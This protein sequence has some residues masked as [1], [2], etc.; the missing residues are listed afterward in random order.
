MTGRARKATASS[1]SGCKRAIFS[2]PQLEKPPNLSRWLFADDARAVM[3]DV[4]TFWEQQETEPDAELR[5][6][7]DGAM[8]TLSIPS[9][10][11]CDADL[12]MIK[13]AHVLGVY[14]I[15]EL[16]SLNG[17]QNLEAMSVALEPAPFTFVVALRTAAFGSS[18][19]PSPMATPSSAAPGTHGTPPSADL[20]LVDIVVT[21]KVGAK[22]V[23]L[24]RPMRVSAATTFAQLRGKVLDGMAADQAA[25]VRSLPAVATAFRSGQ[26]VSNEQVEAARLV[27]RAARTW[28]RPLPSSRGG[29]RPLGLVGGWSGVGRGAQGRW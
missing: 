9:Q 12:I 13:L 14:S 19:S 20:G 16:R 7:V 11:R 29:G 2:C 15:A 18:A 8:K 27:M 1:R 25:Q 26:H 23:A 6:L 5:A 10:K 22:A 3:T 21:A 4:A 24:G 28:V 17:D